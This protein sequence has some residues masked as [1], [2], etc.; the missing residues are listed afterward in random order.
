MDIQHNEMRN[1]R[2]PLD[3]YGV[4][5]DYNNENV[6][7][8][9]NYSFNNEGG[10]A[11]I[12]GGNVDCGYRYNVSVA[13]GE[14]VAGVNGALQNGR[15]FNVSNFCN[16]PAGCPSVGSFIYNNTI[17][18]PADRTPEIFVKAASSFSNLVR[19]RA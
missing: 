16:R 3:S 5:I 2:G 4:H 15:I 9:Y 18:V 12:L 17:F 6:V 19:A 10:F 7:V 11:Q 1:A 8:Q 14:R 13:D